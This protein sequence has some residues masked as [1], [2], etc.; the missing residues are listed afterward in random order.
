MIRAGLAI[1][2][3]EVEQL[4]GKRLR[5]SAIVNVEIESWH[6]DGAF[7]RYRDPCVFLKR[8]GEEAIQSSLRRHCQR[9]RLIHDEV[10]A[11]KPE[12][13]DERALD[14]WGT[15]AAP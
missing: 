14:A 4:G 15:Y 13:I 9:S 6:V 10:A 2:R 11:A 5:E 7:I 8:H 3:M 12:E 1:L